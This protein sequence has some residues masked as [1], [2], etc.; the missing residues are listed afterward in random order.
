MNFMCA[1]SFWTGC[2]VSSPTLGMHTMAIC[3]TKVNGGLC[4]FN[5]DFL[6]IDNHNTAWHVKSHDACIHRLSDYLF[7]GKIIN[8]DY[9]FFC[10]YNYQLIPGITVSMSLQACCKITNSGGGYFL[11]V[12]KMI[13]AEG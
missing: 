1:V 9:G 12:L 10:T 7:S 2:D 11:D 3:P 5:Q 4:L 6:A 13:P 8:I